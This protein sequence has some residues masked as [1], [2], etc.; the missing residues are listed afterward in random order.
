[1]SVCT[2]NCVRDNLSIVKGARLCASVRIWLA[3]ASVGTDVNKISP[4]RISITNCI[5]SKIKWA[6]IISAGFFLRS[7][8]EGVAGVSRQIIHSL[9]IFLEINIVE[10]VYAFVCVAIVDKSSCTSHI[11]CTIRILKFIIYVKMNFNAGVGRFWCLDE[12]C[13][14]TLISHPRNIL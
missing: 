12:G 14:S 6:I 13:V 10:G 4:S 5:N 1:M 8:C 3:A 11:R 9:S 7:I 2:V